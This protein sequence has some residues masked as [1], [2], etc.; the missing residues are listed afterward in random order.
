MPTVRII[1][2]L[3]AAQRWNV[4][5]LDVKSAFLNGD[6]DVK[7]FMNQLEGFIMEGKKSFVCKVKKSLYGLKKAPKA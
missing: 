4:F 3:S 6:L 1:L 5:Q 2:A 7:I